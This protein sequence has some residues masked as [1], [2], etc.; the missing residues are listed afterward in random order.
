MTEEFKKIILEWEKTNRKIGDVMITMK[1]HKKT[2]KILENKI[3]EYMTSNN[4]KD[5]KIE[6]ADVIITIK[7]TKKMESVNRDYM[8]KKC[9]EFLRD[10]KT[11]KKLVDY[12]YNSRTQNSSNC[13][14]RKKKI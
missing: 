5:S 13:L 8:E 10:E 9:I 4:L 1:E 12:I 11:A 14:C 2:S 3:I 6:I 7:D